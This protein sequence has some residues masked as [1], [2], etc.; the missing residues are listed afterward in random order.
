MALL[1][2]WHRNRLATATNQ[3]A[4]IAQKLPSHAPKDTLSDLQDI[5]R[6][7]SYVDFQPETVV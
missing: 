5:Y 1:L 2:E 4:S 3:Y 7:L 6:R